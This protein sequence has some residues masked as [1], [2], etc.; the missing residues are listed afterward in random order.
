M[1][2]SRLLT[3]S[4]ALLPVAVAPA[5]AQGTWP[6]A[7]VNQSRTNPNQFTSGTYTVTCTWTNTLTATSGGTTAYGI[8]GNTYL[9][10][11]AA[12]GDA[13]MQNKAA[14]YTGPST[15]SSSTQ[16]QDHNVS[17]NWATTNSGDSCLLRRHLRTSCNCA[18]S[19][20]GV[21]STFNASGS[22]PVWFEFSLSAPSA[23]GHTITVTV[24][25]AI[26]WSDSINLISGTSGTAYSSY[27]LATGA[28]TSTNNAISGQSTVTTNGGSESGAGSWSWASTPS[29][30][31]RQ[32]DITMVLK[33]DSSGNGTFWIPGCVYCNASISNN[34]ISAMYG[35][36]ALMW[37]EFVPFQFVV[38]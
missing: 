36:G 3:A 20:G 12:S 29:G 26:Q 33:L 37:Y 13:E 23:A 32:T 19:G 24:G 27:T 8:L 14:T 35:A 17:G 16:Y 38:S 31:V 15:G 30:Y 6:P 5:H 10:D 18:G 28:T 4:L 2:V 1:K 21:Y 25:Q 7:Y 11:V 22:S 34:P 9:Q